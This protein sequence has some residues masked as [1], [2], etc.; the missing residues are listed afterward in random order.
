MKQGG[1]DLLPRRLPRQRHP[2]NRLVRVGAWELC[3]MASRSYEHHN[4]GCE[5]RHG[6]GKSNSATDAGEK[7][8]ISICTRAAS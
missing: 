3:E 8:S 7:V 2:S 1:G 5:S 4:S 6:S